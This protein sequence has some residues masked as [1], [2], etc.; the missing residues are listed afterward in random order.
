MSKTPFSSKCLILGALWLNYR[1]DAAANEAWSQFFS[2]NDIALPMAY[3]IAED[4]VHLNSDSGADEL[5]D[6]TW[7]FFC[8]YINIDPDGE[9][10]D[11]AEAFGASEQPP[12]E[13]DNESQ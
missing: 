10:N 4:L 3:M 12:L 11:I 7:K 2:Y 13:F 8:E 9:Y 1:E 5:I 6:E